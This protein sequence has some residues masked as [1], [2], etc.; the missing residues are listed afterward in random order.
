LFALKN[1][2]RFRHKTPEQAGTYIDSRADGPRGGGKKDYLELYAMK[3]NDI[4]VIRQINTA[5]VLDAL[6]RD[7]G[8][9]SRPVMADRLGLSKVTVSTIVRSLSAKGLL[10]EA[11]V[12]DT[13]SRG[14]RRPVLVTLDKDR[15]RVLGARTGHSHI[16]LI[17]SDITGRELR[18]L[19]TEATNQDRRR[20]LADMANEIMISTNTPRESVLGLV[21]AIGGPGAPPTCRSDDEDGHPL[22]EEHALSKMLGF[23]ALMVNFTR[24]RTFSECWF[25][26]GNE[27]A[28][29]FYINLGHR[30]DGMAVRHGQLDEAS[31]EL[32]SCYLSA[33]P[34]ADSNGELRTFNSFLGGRAL[35]EHACMVFDR[36]MEIRELERL[37]A[38]GDERAL[39]LFREFGYY[40]GCALSLV[41]NMASLKKII[42]G[43]HLSRAWPFF[44][45]S[46]REGLERHV[47]PLVYRR[48]E[49]RQLKPELDNGLMGA[50]AIALDH[51]V[52]Q[53]HMLHG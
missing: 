49:V 23:P 36:D 28:S 19:R 17:L 31:C 2:V 14:G 11:G 45:P 6:R 35:L 33:V 42:I 29:L 41:V 39:D 21:N 32:G 40:L 22:A 4:E 34:Y 9:L 20:L 8:Q 38:G 30:L 1:T 27:P 51:W 47:T 7:D 16:E 48:I 26:P 44:E 53:T 50:M 3:N 37:T 13:D 43:G 10:T 18:R 15:K 12:G 5:R 24:A 25:T 46:M 52:F